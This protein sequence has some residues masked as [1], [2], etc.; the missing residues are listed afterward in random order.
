MDETKLLD[1]NEQF[2]EAA[3]LNNLNDMNKLLEGGVDINYRDIKNDRETALHIACRLNYFGMVK[4]LISLGADVNVKDEGFFTPLHEA[5]YSENF[6]I[7]KYLI[8]HGSC[9]NPYTNNRNSPLHIAVG[10]HNLEMVS[11]LV[12]AGAD[13]ECENR[14]NKTP[15][16]MLDFSVGTKFPSKMLEILKL[17]SYLRGAEEVMS[18]FNKLGK[19]K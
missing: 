14:N 16:D 11:Y 3:K 19:N 1:D 2:L 15:R 7:A 12:S 8:D 13:L 6:D 18:Y 5:I 9:V 17:D 10:H 4:F